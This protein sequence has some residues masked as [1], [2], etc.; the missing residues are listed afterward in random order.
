MKKKSL[1]FL[2]FIF[3]SS[4]AFS[5][6]HNLI[7]TWESKDGTSPVQMILD[8]RGFITF[9]ANGQLMGGI[10]YNID[11]EI[12]RMTYRTHQSGHSKTKITIT[13]RDLIKKEI[14]KKDTGSIVF[15]DS[16]NLEMCFKKT[17][18]ESNA[19]SNDCRQ[20]LKIK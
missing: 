18:Q 15:H 13:I 11:G 1:A 19:V 7:G 9:K 14:L 8:Q 10:G 4:I 17:L 20:F 5:Q 12:L 6:H 2:F 16:N 3:V